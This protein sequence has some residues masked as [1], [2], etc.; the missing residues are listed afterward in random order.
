MDGFEGVYTGANAVIV[1]GV[2]TITIDG[3]SG[4]YTHVEGADFTVEAYIDGSYYEI[5]LDNVN[6]VAVVVKPMV[7][8]TYDCGDY[9]SLE[10]LVVNKNIAITLATPFND[11]YTFRGWFFD[12]EYTNAVPA[13]FVPTEDVTVFAKWAEKVVLTVVYGN[14]LDTVTYDYSVGD[15][16]ALVV[17][18]A[19]NGLYFEGWYEDADFTTAFTAT[20]ISGNVTVYCNWTDTIPY[21]IAQYNSAYSMVYNAETGAWTTT[22]QGAGSSYCGFTITADNVDIEIT[23]DYTVSS[24]ANWDILY[25]YAN[26]QEMLGKST[27]SGEKSG[28]ITVTL[29]AG[30]TLQLYYKKDSGGNKGS[31]TATITNLTVAG[32]PVTEI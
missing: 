2:K 31:D 30:N 27:G 21:T 29:R 26:G 13:S 15:T 1:D 7:T 20:T 6:Y 5:T 17:P 4:E 12:A 3:V 18:G 16:I 11:A 28:T 10:A 19:T 22:N 9:D 8:V 23:F 32:S 14:G 24:E 25:V